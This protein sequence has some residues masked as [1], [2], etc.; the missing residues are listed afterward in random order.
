MYIRVLVYF[1]DRKYFP[2]LKNVKFLVLILNSCWKL[3]CAGEA[4]KL[5]NWKIRL[6]FILIFRNELQ[7]F[8]RLGYVRLG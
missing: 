1:G 6:I 5:R 3:R 2:L 7:F 8:V 4:G